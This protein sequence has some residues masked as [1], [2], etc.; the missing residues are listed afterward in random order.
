M[1]LTW[2]CK[3]PKEGGESVAKKDI[4]TVMEAHVTELMA[5]PGVTGVAVSAL[6]DGS[7]CVLVL[8]QE[9]SQEIKKKIPQTLDGYPVKIEVSGTIVPMKGDSAG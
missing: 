6:D 4:N 5:I 9:D 3:E 2:S 1:A 7:L 8:I